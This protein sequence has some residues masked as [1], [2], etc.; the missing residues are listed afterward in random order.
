M[1]A[2]KMVHVYLALQAM[3]LMELH[4]PY[5]QVAQLVF[6]AREIIF[7]FVLIAMMDII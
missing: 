3:L 1:I 2:M 7:Q 5:A 4:A 6:N